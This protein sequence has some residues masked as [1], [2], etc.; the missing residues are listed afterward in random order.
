[1]DR[2]VIIDINTRACQLL[3]YSREEL[4][5]QSPMLY[6]HEMTPE[7]LQEISQRLQHTESLTFE[8]NHIDRWG[9]I[10]PVEVR[11]RRFVENGQSRAVALVLDITERRQAEAARASSEQKL[12]RIGNALPNGALLS[13]LSKTSGEIVIEHAS[14]GFWPMLGYPVDAPPADMREVVRK[15][16][17]R[18]LAALRAVLRKSEQERQTLDELVSLTLDGGAERW[19]H[20]RFVPTPIDRASTRW[21]GV[22]LDVTTQLKTQQALTESNEKY[23]IVTE[24]LPQLVWVLRSD[25]SLEY[26]SPSALAFT[27]LE[28][29]EL[30]QRWQDLI[31]PEDRQHT[32]A[33]LSELWAKQSEVQIELRARR[34]DGQYRWMLVKPAP[35]RDPARAQG[36]WLGAAIDIHDRKLAE[37]AREDSEK[38]LQ[39]LLH[40]ANLLV[41]E[42]QPQTRQFTYVSDYCER[43]LGYTRQQW[44]APDFWIDHLHPDD[45]SDML[46]I[47]RQAAKSGT[48]HRMEYRM[49][50]A[51]G[52][53][54]WIEDALHV[55]IV[56]GQVVSMRGVIQDISQRKQLE[57]QLRQS[58]KMEA[59][60]R[61][62]GGVA[63]DFNNILTVMMGYSELLLFTTPT[64]DPNRAAITAIND[65]GKRAAA[66]TRQLLTFSR[67]AIMAPKVL[68]LNELVRS[69]EA[70]LRPTIGED[71]RLTIEIDPSIRPIKADRVH[72][73]QVLMN[74]AINA[75]DAMPQGGWMNIATRDQVQLPASIRPNLDEYVELTLS[76]SGCGISEELIGK[77]FDPFFTTKEVGRGTGLGLSVVH[78]VVSGAGGFIHVDSQPGVGTTFHL[79][80]PATPAQED[81]AVNQLVRPQPRGA[82]TILLV[83]DDQAVRAV[84]LATLTQQGFQVIDAGNGEQ[85]LEKFR[86]DPN[87]IDVLLTD[88]VMPGMSGRTLAEEVRAIK[89]AIPVL[90]MSGHT[91]DAVV[92]HG[93]R[94]HADAFIQKPFHPY[95]LGHKLRELLAGM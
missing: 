21:E 74:L 50:A 83:E 80:F 20:A 17:R 22:V 73:E 11:L 46:A 86:R 66:L 60:G 72:I 36:K 32:F 55:Q 75:R 85:A 41:W 16:P 90:Y 71:I 82:E 84:T 57:D 56:D 4:I 5:G 59:I 95:A 47:V 14:A 44:L 35:L 93:I 69:T 13:F 45:A 29:S 67:K 7:Q 81:A 53:V 34:Y 62:A 68:D 43:L 42:A 51:D 64:A 31:H 91:D 10:F 87:S 94:S 92:Q 49:L 39:L 89:P 28:L 15:L 19:L 30:N 38:R 37:Q 3:G 33:A 76:D 12:L 23:R 18:Q 52:R 2:G 27:G 65:A 26:V 9:R 79:C 77:I 61:L 40:S 88:V 8:A 24:S 63:H 25:Y 54:V 1:N 70:L 58:Q 48:D 78:G 6:N